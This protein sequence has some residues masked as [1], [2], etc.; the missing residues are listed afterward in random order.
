ME[1]KRPS[2]RRRLAVAAVSLGLALVAGEVALGVWYEVVLGKERLYRYDPVTGWDN[3]AGLDGSYV[4]GE[5]RVPVRLVTDA[6][7][8]PVYEPIHFRA[9]A[10]EV[11]LLG[12]SFVFGYY[13]D[14]EAS[15]AAE[16]RRA[17]AT[18]IGGF[19]NHGVPSFSADQSFLRYR[20][21]GDAAEP[22]VVLFVMFEN[23]YLD[24]DLF[25]SGTRD[26]PVLA[27]DASGRLVEVEGA[28]P[29]DRL[30]D[31]SY[32]VHFGLYALG[33]YRQDRQERLGDSK[34]IWRAI[35]AAWKELADTRGD[36]LAVVYHHLPRPLS[37]GHEFEPGIAAH[38]GSLGVPYLH[39]NA[40]EPISAEDLAADGWHW[41]AEAQPRLGHAVA[42]WLLARSDLVPPE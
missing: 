2:R 33:R 37:A 36:R 38:L 23:D 27:A 29:F 3:A 30:R 40:V 14:V 7:G 25:L 1:K 8:R 16:L 18:R 4:Q 35:L 41:K 42:R 26:K 13:V 22:R 12:D 10:P 5:D 32:L 39:L 34:G 19:V 21:L 15:F 28:N 11:L 20:S 31:A 9:G 6:G 17:L 24:N